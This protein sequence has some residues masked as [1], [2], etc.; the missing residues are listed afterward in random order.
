M[1]SFPPIAEVVDA[2]VHAVL[3]AFGV[4]ALVAGGMTSLFGRRF[5]YVAA[6]V[7]FLA[8]FAVANA[9]RGC[10]VLKFNPDSVSP[11]AD[12]LRGFFAVMTGPR[13]IPEGMEAEAFTSPPAG[14]YWI[15]WAALITTLAGLVSHL[16]SC[17]RYLRWPVVL[18]ATAIATRMIVPAQFF[19]GFSIIPALVWLDM[20]MIW[21]VAERRTARVANLVTLAAAG[22]AS[23]GAAAVLLHAHSAR[24]TDVATLIAFAAL[25]L[26][27]AALW[28]P[29]NSAGAFPAIA[30]LL[31][32]ALISGYHET[33][34]SIPGVAFAL[35]ALA[36]VTL[37]ILPAI[38]ERFREGWKEWAVSA[39]LVA[40]P[41][42]AA[43]ILAARSESLEF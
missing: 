43:I 13:V 15:P 26:A 32:G 28:L 22:L 27:F 11:I 18:V 24:L 19:Y 34:S 4:S 3:P 42:L 7:G 9:F 20:V 37:G 10:F 33:F 36:P 6:A 2:A 12:L 29:V 1:S 31:P 38:P 30:V 40:V 14:R 16:T 25:G 35:P 23:I 21:V 39:C 8:G 5:G 17:P 41:T